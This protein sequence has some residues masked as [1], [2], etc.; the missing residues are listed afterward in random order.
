[1]TNQEVRYSV[2]TISTLLGIAVVVCGCLLTTAK[3]SYSAGE[4]SMAVQDS[5]IHVNSRVTDN[6]VALADQSIK[7]TD[8]CYE[9]KGD[10]QEIRESVQSI[11]KS[12]AVLAES[13]KFTQEAVRRIE[14]KTE[15]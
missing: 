6:K 14:K 4:Q 2:K 8:H 10:M 3:I 13:Q 7:F 11:D 9:Q 15:P 12:I 1:M 5:L